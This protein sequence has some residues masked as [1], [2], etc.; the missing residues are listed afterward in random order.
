MEQ[1]QYKKLPCAFLEV[2][3]EVLGRYLFS[4]NPGK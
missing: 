4:G 3:S 1:T 2:L